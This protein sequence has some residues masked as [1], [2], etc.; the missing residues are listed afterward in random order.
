M[1]LILEV[2]NYQGLEVLEIYILEATR[3]KT[4][5][6][7]NKENPIK[8]E[9]HPNDFKKVEEG[10]ESVIRDKEEEVKDR[11]EEKEEI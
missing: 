7:L 2:D 4:E 9:L 10:L 3:G 8:V 6:I 11:T 5:Y 1:G